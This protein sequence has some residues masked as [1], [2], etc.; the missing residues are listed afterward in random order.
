MDTTDDILVEQG[1]LLSKCSNFYIPHVSKVRTVRGDPVRIA[2]QVLVTDSLG[3]F[4]PWNIRSPMR[5]VRHGAFASRVSNV[6]FLSK[7]TRIASSVLN[8][9]YRPTRL[10]TSHQS[11]E[12]VPSRN[13]SRRNQRTPTRGVVDK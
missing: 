9:V 8:R 10:M 1:E 2:Y 4:A 3:T 6:F 11:H 13:R 7:V 5:K 12:T